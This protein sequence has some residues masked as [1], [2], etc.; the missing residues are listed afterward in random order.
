M[1]LSRMLARSKAARSMMGGAPAPEEMPPEEEGPPL[2]P[3]LGPEPQG[4]AA[5]SVP[6]EDLEG[7]L[8]G[9]E[10]SIEGLDPEKA[11]EV[12]MHLNAIRELVASGGEQAPPEGAPPPGEE[13]PPPPGPEGQSALGGMI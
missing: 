5:E 1:P 13:P 2:P 8:A 4:P 3:E 9:V 6:A 12:R 10:A 11:E 7:A